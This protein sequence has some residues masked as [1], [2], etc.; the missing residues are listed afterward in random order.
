MLVATSR[1]VSSRLNR[2][3]PAGASFVDFEAH[4]EP[5]RNLPPPRQEAHA[6]Y[7]FM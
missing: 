3:H 1:L 7:N 5:S 4:A 2:P 6:L